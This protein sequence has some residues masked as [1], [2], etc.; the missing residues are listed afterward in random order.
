PGFG[1]ILQE[2]MP[3]ALNAFDELSFNEEGAFLN[4]DAFPEH[5]RQ[6]A[7]WILTLLQNSLA[8]EPHFGCFGMHEWAMVYKAENLRHSQLPLRM[9][10]DELA[11]FVD[12][13]P[14]VCTHFDAFRFFTEE[15]KPH[16]KFEL[17]R[18]IFAE[19][20]QP[21]CLHTNMDLYKWAFKMFPWISSE[22]IRSAFLM[23]LE[24]RKID[25]QAS[26][27][28]LSEHGLQPI[29][30]ETEKGRLEYLKHQKDIYRR[31]LPIRKQLIE[32]YQYLLSSI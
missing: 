22:L 16:N 13:R 28:D 26:P 2:A 24:T 6:S 3:E 21:G 25:M 29:K 12:S 17:S 15:A 4:P 18:E 8:K 20:E 31:S 19:I 7:E 1:L 23:A 5:R 11:A 27:Y 10:M 30:I 14:L 32:Q 9:P